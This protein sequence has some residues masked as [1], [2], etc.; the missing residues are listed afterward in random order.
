MAKDINEYVAMRA[1]KQKSTGQDDY[2]NKT[3]DREMDAQFNLATRHEDVVLVSI[4]LLR[5]YDGH[6]FKPY[7][8]ERLDAL[9]ESIKR[10][11]LHQP[12]IVR[13]VEGVTGYEI[14]SGHN[15][16]EAM[17]RLGNRDIS[18]IIRKLNDIEA[19]L[20]VVNTNLEQRENLLPSEK[21]FAYKM[22][23][24]AL[25]NGEKAIIK[26]GDLF[27]DTNGLRSLT[28]IELTGTIES[29]ADVK[30]VDR[31][32]VQRYIRLTYL[33][34]ELLDL[35]DQDR[36]P[37]MAGYELSFLDAE[38]QNTVLDYF[39]REGSKAKLSIKNAKDIR[40]VYQT[41]RQIDEAALRS[42]LEKTPKKKGPLTY[43]FSRKLLF[44]DYALP[45]GF[46]FNAFVHE[47]LREAFG[48][49]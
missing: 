18:A 17:K 5:P 47:K 32:D 15:R 38:A 26:N 40:M 22:Q 27:S 31:N 42:I 49:I 25:Q 6:P 35:L 43:S 12:I 21:A 2:A 3:L 36:Y 34:P 33:I 39:F 44:K 10:D 30:G 29:V 8:D 9:A 19:M 46:D 7:R 16:V 23:M 28:Q 14:L 13:A 11:G 37:V 48:R 41:N 4:R 45:D 1:A 24:E 20:L